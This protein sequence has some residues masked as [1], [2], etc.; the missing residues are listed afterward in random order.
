LGL[1]SA[2][3]FEAA[4]ESAQIDGLLKFEAERG[5]GRFDSKG[6]NPD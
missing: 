5:G 6:V 3:K 2:E 1:A 4:G